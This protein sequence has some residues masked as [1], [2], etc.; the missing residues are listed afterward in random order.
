MCITHV[1]FSVKSEKMNVSVFYPEGLLPLQEY[2][3][4][5]SMEHILCFSFRPGTLR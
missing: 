2:L 5:A 1:L 4:E 3:P